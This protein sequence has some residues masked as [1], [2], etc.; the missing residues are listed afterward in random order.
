M[1]QSCEDAFNRLRHQGLQDGVMDITFA[2]DVP[3]IPLPPGPLPERR[4]F[5]DAIT[6]RA[7][8][9]VPSVVIKRSGTLGIE[10]TMTR[11]GVALAE[12][13]V[14]IVVGDM[15]LIPLSVEAIG[16]T[17]AVPANDLTTTLTEVVDVVAVEDAV[18]G[19]ETLT[20]AGVVRSVLVDQVVMT[21]LYPIIFRHL[22]HRS[23][24]LIRS[25][26]QR[27]PQ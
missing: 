11:C 4:V 3:D 8:L 17:N 12:E 2:L 10:D 6:C 15:Q 18:E 21:P 24:P 7:Q 25:R 5:E 22:R 13:A 19:L 16:T 9:T 20:P 23:H 26:F 14:E 1:P 27:L